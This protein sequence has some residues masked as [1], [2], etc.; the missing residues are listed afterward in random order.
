MEWDLMNG[1]PQE[2][3]QRP[4]DAIIST[5]AL[6]HFTDEQKSL[7]ITQ[8]LQHLSPTGKF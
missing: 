3:L 5:Y 4:Y 8:L 7:Y 1:L 2:L 6:H